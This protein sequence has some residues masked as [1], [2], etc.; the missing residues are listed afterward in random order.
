MADR[1]LDRARRAVV[2]NTARGGLPRRSALLTTASD[3][4]SASRL[5]GATTR[6]EGVSHVC[7]SAYVYHPATR[8]RRWTAGAPAR[9]QATKKGAIERPQRRRACASTPGG[10]HRLT[11]LAAHG[12]W[13]ASSSSYSWSSSVASASSAR[14]RLR[15]T[16]V[17]SRV[18]RVRVSRRPIE[19]EARADSARLSCAGDVST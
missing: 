5:L 17:S 19:R 12:R 14:Q 9:S 1:G 13:R 2:R 8:L 11:R 7:D 3:H 15:A 4:C 6:M 18:S 10:Q 16:A